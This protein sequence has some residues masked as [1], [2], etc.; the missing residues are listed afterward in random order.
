MVKRSR[1]DS[2]PLLSADPSSP[3][4]TESSTPCTPNS[5]NA[6]HPDKYFQTSASSPTPHAAAMKCSLAPHPETLTFPTFEAFEIHYAQTHS[7]RCQECS[8]NF[9]TEHFLGL[10]ISEYH[11]PLVEA[12][13]ARGEKTYRCFVEGCD[14]ICLTWQKRRMHL[15]NKHF[16]PPNYDFFIV[17]TG[18]DRRS[19]MLRTRHRRG[20]SSAASRALQR[21]QRSH[22]ADEASSSL[23][24]ATGPEE[25][26]DQT[27]SKSSSSPAQSKDLDE[28]TA[29][30]SSLKFVP[31]SIRFGRGGRRGGLSRS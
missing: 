14:K 29:T 7:N 26:M 8:K 15:K 11:D 5:L 9:P 13:K 6:S 31:P 10:H 16:F 23:K 2:P 22:G 21:E 30:M 19:S 3:S 18:I 20:S 12:R 27:S 25:E 1:E 4:I 28:L 24:E 17:G